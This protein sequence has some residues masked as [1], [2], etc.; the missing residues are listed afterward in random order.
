MAERPP[1]VY[2]PSGGN[3][4]EV[5]LSDQVSVGVISA[6]AFSTINWVKDEMISLA[7]TNFS[8]LS[9]G[10][11]SLGAGGTITVGAGCSYV[12]L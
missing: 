1:I 8:Y 10:P 7:S 3:I 4:E 5:P 2:D 9:V 6:R 12:V 11:G